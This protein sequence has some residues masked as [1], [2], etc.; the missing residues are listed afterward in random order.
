[1]HALFEPHVR[2]KY[3]GCLLAKFKDAGLGYPLCLPVFQ[4]FMRA[5]PFF[6]GHTSFKVGQITRQLFKFCYNVAAE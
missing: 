6:L 2:G 1:M 4:S 5:E 3:L